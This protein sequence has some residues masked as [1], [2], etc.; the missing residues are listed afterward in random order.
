MS[1][2]QGDSIGLK[3]GTVR[4]ADYAPR[5]ADLF[6]QE[7]ERLL[8]SVAHLVVD[9]QHVGSTAV[10][11]LCAKPIIDIAIAIESKEVIPSLVRRLTR[12]G[13][14]DRGDAGDDGGYLLV[15]ER[16][17]EVRAAHIHIVEAT[18]VQWRDYIG[19]RDL[20]RR[21]EDTR[22]EYGR[23]KRNLAREYEADRRSYTAG[24]HGFIRAL[25]DER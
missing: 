17:P 7:A 5:W 14:I 2:F 3:R 9:I 25:L 23:L 10:T 18:D 12:L 24:K 21:N 22:E 8:Q 4:I 11:G 19:F 6:E 1:P 13:Y 20:L 16:A 15:L